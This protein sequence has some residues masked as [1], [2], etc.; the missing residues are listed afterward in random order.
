MLLAY[1]ESV[2]DTQKKTLKK[3]FKEQYEKKIRKN[4]FQGIFRK[5][6]S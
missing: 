5:K 3:L 2:L 6:L 4:T 1:V